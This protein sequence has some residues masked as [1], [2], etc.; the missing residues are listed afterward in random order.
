MRLPTDPSQFL[1]PPPHTLTVLL[2]GRLTF[3]L[4]PNLILRPHVSDPDGD[5]GRKSTRSREE[6]GSE[7]IM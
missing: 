5:G 4:I 1:S 3:M 2:S 6:S 7:M